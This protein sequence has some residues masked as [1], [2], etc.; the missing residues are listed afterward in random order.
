M[1]WRGVVQIGIGIQIGIEDCGSS[2]WIP[3]AIAIWLEHKRAEPRWKAKWG[4]ARIHRVMLGIA[5]NAA[6]SEQA[7]DDGETFIIVI[8]TH[9]AESAMR[10]TLTLDPDVAARLRLLQRRR[11]AKQKALVNQALRIGLQSLDQETTA[12]ARPPFV[13]REV[14]LGC[15]RYGDVD[16][17]ADV[18]AVADGEAQRCACRQK[19]PLPTPSTPTAGPSTTARSRP[20]LKPSH[21][22]RH[23]AEV[24]VALL[25]AAGLLAPAR[26]RAQDAATDRPF[27]HPLFTDHMVL[28]R[29]SGTRV[30][31]WT[32]PGREVTVTLAGQT[33]T[34]KADAN[35]RWLATLPALAAGGP[36]SLTVTGPQTV[37]IQ[38]V[39]V[40]D[41]WLCSG[42]SNMQMSVSGSLNAKEEIAA[43]TH[44]RIRF[45]SVPWAGMRPGR[46]RLMHTEPQA[47]AAAK[48]EVCSPETAGGFSAIAYF[49]ARDLQAAVDVPIG[50]I[51]A[52]VGGSPITAWCAP[53]LLADV[54]AVQP[55]LEALE[56]LRGL[57]RENKIGEEYFKEVVEQ[58]WNANDPGTHEG[59]FKPDASTDGWLRVTLPAGGGKA[60]VPPFH[61]IVW[62]R[63]ELEV[64]ADWVGKDLSLYRTGIWEPDTT[65]FNGSVVGA[66]DQGWINR[67]SRIP[68]ALVKPG[69]NVV[70]VRVLAQPG[71]GYQGPAATSRLELPGGQ[72]QPIPLDG[73]RFL[74]PSTPA[75]K[76]PPFPHRL[77]DD[78]QLPT[79]LYNGMIAPLTPYALKGFLWYQGETPCPGG[80][81]VHRR[82]LADMIADWRARF[83]SPEAWF[84]IVQLPVLGGAPTLDPAAT[85]AAEIRAVQWDVGQAVPNAATAVITDLGDPHDI[86]PKNKQDVG[87]RLA[88]IAQARVYGQAVAHSGPVLRA[89]ACEGNAVRVTYDHLGG[90]LV[91]KGDKLEGF[92]LAGADGKWVWAEAT[93][94][95][96]AVLVSSPDVP[97]PKAVRYD[98]VD[99]PRYRLWNQAGLP[100]APFEATVAP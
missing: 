35:G 37:E 84:L 72:A 83:A 6:F 34:G 48:W 53:S 82:L 96:D 47:T 49:F 67:T 65:W 46:P 27:L 54:P 87:R 28:Q 95:G 86:H 5:G 32:E 38:D 73:E 88:L 11:Q 12:A 31:G 58:W 56:T 76:L 97:A 44:P 74:R 81:A 55:G 71:R 60:D 33:A 18:L 99:V 9:Q 63:K 100:A 52:A 94:D 2:I 13:T 50:L 7:W 8:T 23:A 43:A 29:D 39:L 24:I 30:W 66:F 10:T 21:V 16:N 68:A 41:V 78:F 59:W 40:G 92:A 25:L 70:A 77:D 22:R 69:R 20:T 90:G 89:A 4:S 62:F 80:H 42:Q 85:G 61:G 36:H 15:C 64:P 75:A 19:M 26:L 98:F 3:I 17:V 93:I 57:V 79:V 45:F 14:D 51:R 91:V 1:G